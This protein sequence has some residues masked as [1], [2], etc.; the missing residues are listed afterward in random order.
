MRHHPQVLSR[1]DTALVIID[2]QER[3]NGVM[4][5]QHHV[6]R[7]RVLKEAWALLDLPM[8]V[9]EQYPQGLG[10]TIDDLAP[11]ADN[12]PLA[13]M[14]FSCAGESG[15]ATAITHLGIRQVV[16]TGIETHVCVAQTAL[17]L[18]HAGYQVHVPHDAVNSRRPTDRR[19]TLER[20]ARAGVVVTSTESVLF[21]I[22]DRCGTDDFRAVSR[23]V[24]DLPVDRN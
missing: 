21:E 5:D 4:A 20:L 14:T 9:T 18:L 1:A 16:V 10:V 2:V 13:K 15:F 6:A 19:W 12:P 17:D 7:T 11:S 22:L 24:K 3:I 8:V 23:L